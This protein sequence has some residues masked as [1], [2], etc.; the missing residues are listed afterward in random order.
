MR[1]WTLLTVVGVVAILAGGYFLL[2]QP[3]KDKVAELKTTAAAAR[4]ANLALQSDIDR[5]NKLAKDLP[6]QQAKLAA[7]AQRIPSNPALPT[8][9]RSLTDAADTAGV[10]LV[11]LAPSEPTAVV[12]AAPVPVAGAKVGTAAPA[13]AVTAAAPAV[14]TEPLFVIPIDV[15]VKGGFVQL[16]QFFNNLEDLPRSFQVGQFVVEPMDEKGPGSSV[17]SN[18]LEATLGGRVY[19]TAPAPAPVAPV[20]PAAPAVPAK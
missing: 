20:K 5:L 12:A 2:V 17:V 1:Q 6:R 7:F 18:D 11:S 10:E 16:Q 9:I 8:L 13:G 4:A 14:G 3:K 15:T 19:M